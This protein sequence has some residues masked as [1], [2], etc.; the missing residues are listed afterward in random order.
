MKTK[1]IIMLIL[2][3]SL[4]TTYLGYNFISG[5]KII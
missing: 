1:L 3:C 4:L 2:I 5:S